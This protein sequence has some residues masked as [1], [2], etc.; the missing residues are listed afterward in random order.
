MTFST[1]PA[2]CHINLGAIGR[3]F[4]RLGDASRLMPVIKSDAYGHGLV[5]VAET[6][7][8][9]GATRF[10]V[11]TVSEGLEL[12]RGGFGQMLVPLLGC[13]DK[14]E[15]L[16][17]IANN[18]A[19]LAGSFADLELAAQA[20]S[21]LGAPEARI[22]LKCDTGMARLGFS[23]A[24]LPQL[25]ERLGRLPLRP[26]MLVSHLACADD[27]GEESFTRRQLEGFA[28]FR[29]ALAPLFPDLELSLENSAATL[30]A[31]L[32]RFDVARPGIAI[33]GG[34][35]LAG[36]GLAARG[37]GFEWAM[38][39]SAP[40]IHIRELAP[41]QSVS[42]GRTFTAP[43]PMRVAV[44]ACGYANGISRRLSNNCSFLVAGRRAPQL[45]RVCMG[46]SLADI[47]QIPSVMPGDRAWFMGGPAAAGDTPVTADELALA[48]GTISYEI[49]CSLGNLNQRVYESF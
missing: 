46:M 10:A 8:A 48:L 5:R 20:A 7:T 1:S 44:L 34:N 16:E 40:V 31:D 38:S 32:G 49:L 41:G 9:C 14:G 18:L 21:E 22:V 15:W 17:A 26:V 43:R 2:R 24:D 6:L 35:P 29:R 28:A 36:T 47:S 3:N 11:G 33:Y 27:P 23:S 45:G 39:V 12:R 25:L 4:K 19:P 37:D 42:Y 13:L 30:R